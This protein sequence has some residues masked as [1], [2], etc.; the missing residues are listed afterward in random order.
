MYTGQLIIDN[1]CNY[2]SYAARN[3]HIYLWSLDSNKENIPPNIVH[4]RTK[5]VES[6]THA[7]EYRNTRPPFSQGVQKRGVSAGDV[8]NYNVPGWKTPHNPFPLTL[9]LL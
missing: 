7:T 8:F 1:V 2:N 6:S 9:S 5:M 4:G 3:L